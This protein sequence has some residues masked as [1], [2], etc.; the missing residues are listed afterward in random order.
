MWDNIKQFFIGDSV[1]KANYLYQAPHLI[2][3]ALAIIATIVLVLA[4]KNKSDKTKRVVLWVFFAIFLAFEILS[5]V[6]NIIKGG[7]LFKIL[8]PMHFC[9]IMV[10]IIIVSIALN[11]KPLYSISALGGL[12]A[13]TAYLLYPAVGLN[14][15]VLNFSAFYSIFSHTLGFV[16]SVWLIACGF[17]SYKFKNMWHSLV[18]A[19]AVIGYSAILNFVIYPGENYMYYVKNPFPFEI[20]AWFQVLYAAVVLTYI[21]IFYVTYYFVKKHKNKISK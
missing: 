16:A 15:E 10:W 21:S 8:A 11:K 12:L 18:F 1:K 7:D 4:F 20:G 14:V 2:T 19:G 9:S 17:T 5:R 3:L 6:F 13:T